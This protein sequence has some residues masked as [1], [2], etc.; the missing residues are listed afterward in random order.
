MRC[1]GRRAKRLDAS[2]QRAW[3]FGQEAAAVESRPDLAKEKA[4]GEQWFLPDDSRGLR[5][6]EQTLSQYLIEHGLGWVVGLRAFMEQ[7]DFSLM[8]RAYSAK[9]RCALHPRTLLGL[10]VYGMV[11]RQWTLRELETL[12]KCDA[13]A[14]LMCGG[15]QPDHSTIGKFIQLH[16]ELLS[17]EFFA[18]LMRQIAGRLK[19]RAGVAAVDATVI[20]AASGRFGLLRAEAAGARAEEARRAA[21]EHPQD[22]GLAEKAE[23]A[24]AAAAA[25]EQRDARRSAK[26][27]QGQVKVAP[28]EPEAMYQPRKD[29]VRCASYKPAVLV[30]QAPCELES[31]PAT[32]QL[33]AAQG[34]HPSSEP[35]LFTGLLDQ[36]RRVLG[37][38]PVTVL[39]DAGYSTLEILVDS[40]KR[41]L[42]L[43][44]PSGRARGDDDW[45]K[46]G[47]SGKFS[48]HAFI[49]DAERDLCRC[50]AGRELLPERPRFD[51]EGREYRR[52]VAASCEGCA[53]RERCTDSQ[54]GRTLKRYVNDEYKEA[55]V[56]VMGQ[57]RAR[58]RYRLRGALVERIFAELRERQG[59]KRFRRRGLLAV[60]AEFALHCMAYNLKQAA[61]CWWLVLPGFFSRP[62][63][64]CATPDVYFI[65]LIT[66]SA[67]PI[68]L[69]CTVLL[70]TSATPLSTVS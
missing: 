1:K 35:A 22:T 45:S 42:D 17:D 5:V 12:A 44:C 36:H 61:A 69:N 19:L 33:I 25:V 2:G 54:T 67:A 64:P 28:A 68:G 41:G 51:R 53:L 24:Q 16:S 3:E 10:I 7:L 40:C 62:N 46:R 29:G 50:P 20:E 43:L 6:Q 26:G 55:M 21:A 58:A 8:L 52:Y 18:D 60:R 57:G 15:H 63:S 66:I 38:D 13:G 59:L 70:L 14:W 65:V 11:K 30:E 47:K 34:V 27:S 9:G 56:E 23:L 4:P 31:G 39:A 32:V 48:K 37:C 49:Y